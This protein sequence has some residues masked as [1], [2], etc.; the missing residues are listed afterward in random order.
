MLLIL[1]LVV[2]VLALGGGFYGSG[3]GWGSYGWSPLGIL[4]VVLVI[5]WATGNLNL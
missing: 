3:A 2:L 4:L 1:L 5:L